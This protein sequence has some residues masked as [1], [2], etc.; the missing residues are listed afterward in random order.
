[1]RQISA[2]LLLMAMMSIPTGC[3]WTGLTNS[4]WAM[5]NE[6]YEEKYSR[7]YESEGARALPRKVKQ[8]ADARFQEEATGV[9]TSIGFGTDP[10]AFGGDLGFSHYN[11]SWLESHLSLSGLFNE[12]SEGF[13]LGGRAG[14]RIQPPSRLAPFVGIGLFAGFNE[15]DVIADSDGRDNNDNRVVDEA[16]E[17]AEKSE[18]LG[19]LYPEMGVHYW[20]NPNCRLTTSAAY[21]VTTSG[22]NYDN[23]V[24][25]VGIGGFWHD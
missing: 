12:G 22:R 18:F 25:S 17:L 15:Y 2:L 5:E 4:R 11:T 10:D 6:T 13:N 8:A 24:F 3:A 21:H 1:M 16:G 7:P 14:V 23:W 9:F 19:S 20:I